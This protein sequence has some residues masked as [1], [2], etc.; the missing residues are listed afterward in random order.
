MNKIKS[1]K[2][3][4]LISLVVTIIILLILAGISIQALTNTG[5]F[6]RAKE[7]NIETRG[8]SVQ[9]ARDLWKMNQE[10][11]NYGEIGTAETLEEL[12]DDLEKQKLITSEE[13]TKIDETGEVTIGSKTIVFKEKTIA[14]Y[15]KIGDYVAYTPQAETT[16][17][18]FE[19]KYTGYT[20]DQAINQDS[21]KWRVLNINDDGTV[22]LIS[23]TPTN[24]SVYFQGALGYNNGVYLLNDFCNTLYGNTTK[25]ATAR[26]LNIEDIEEKMDLSVWDYHNYTS[27]GTDTK[28]GDTCIYKNQYYPYQWTQEKT[29]KSK[30]DG[31]AVTGT[32]GKSEQSKLTEQ[33]SLQA[34]TSIETQQTVWTRDTSN[35]ISNFQSAN[36]RDTTKSLNIYYELL[37]NNGKDNY[38]LSS[39]GVDNSNPTITYFGL[40]SI[41]SGSVYFLW[42]FGSYFDDFNNGRYIRPIVSIPS[43]IIDINTDYETTEIWN[44]K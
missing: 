44:L 10:L 32:L 39:R 13:R 21:L 28:Y 22:D 20:S 40:Y 5:L 14:D 17:Y 7:A 26:S 36:T 33:T 43:S 25:G 41:H 3:I 34:T 6:A 38:W 35:M 29:D 23:A 31:N 12:L 15:I 37:C 24:T 16:S 11:D 42:M 19:A 27:S 30:I 2:G 1:T 8:A 9:E 4:T 18:N